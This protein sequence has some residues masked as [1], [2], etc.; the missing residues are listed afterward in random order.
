MSL[1]TIGVP[2]ETTDPTS[3]PSTGTSD[4][5][6]EA[7]GPVTA[8]T[9]R[10][11]PSSTTSAT[12]PLSACSRSAAASAISWSRAPIS[13]LASSVA[14][15]RRSRSSSRLRAA[16][17]ASASRRAAVWLRARR[18][19]TYTTPKVMPVASSASRMPSQCP[20]NA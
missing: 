3:E 10:N 13:L 15:T 1:V 12:A 17:E 7:R 6:A 11:R 5:M 20:W 19:P 9:R 18:S 4:P 2:L 14:A 8:A 16:A